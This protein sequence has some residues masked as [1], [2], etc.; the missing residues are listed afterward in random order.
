MQTVYADVLII[1]NIYVNFFL[2]RTTARVTHS[3]LRTFRCIAASVYGSLFSLT[4]LLPSLGTPLNIAIKVAAAV[5]AV[6]VADVEYNVQEI[7]KLSPLFWQVSAFT[8]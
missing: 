3:P 8:A 1:L 6:K 2:L 4:I 5:P 7:E